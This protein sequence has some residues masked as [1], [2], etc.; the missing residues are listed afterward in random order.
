MKISI[1]ADKFHFT[2][3]VPMILVSMIGPFAIK[4]IPSEKLTHETKTWILEIFPEIIDSLKN[5]RGMTLV[6]IETAKGE[7]VLI[8]M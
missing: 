6:D 3:P 7:K 1:S 8:K 5:C 2:L 4:C